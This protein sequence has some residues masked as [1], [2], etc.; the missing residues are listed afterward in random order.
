MKTHRTYL[1]LGTGGTVLAW[2][3]P[4]HNIWTIV[5]KVGVIMAARLTPQDRD[6]NEIVPCGYTEQILIMGFV[7]G[8]KETGGTVITLRRLPVFSRLSKNCALEIKLLASMRGGS[9]EDRT[10]HTHTSNCLKIWCEDK[11]FNEFQAQWRV[12][13]FPDDSRYQQELSVAGQ[14]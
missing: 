2:Q 6:D 11:H 13:M 9:W 8:A 12:V 7:Q 5:H 4:D 10:K 3:L 14:Q 1:F